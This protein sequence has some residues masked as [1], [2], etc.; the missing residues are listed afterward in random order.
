[1]SLF[2]HNGTLI[3]EPDNTPNTT[4]HVTYNVK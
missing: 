3:V 4:L 2:N 1:M